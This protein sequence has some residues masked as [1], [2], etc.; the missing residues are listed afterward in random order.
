MVISISSTNWKV[1]EAEPTLLRYR[2]QCVM[3]RPGGGA[4]MLTVTES[5]WSTSSI[6]L[7]GDGALSQ[8]QSV[9]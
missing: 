8:P 6:S 3:W 7:T 4:A 2:R 1:A 9:T 5:F